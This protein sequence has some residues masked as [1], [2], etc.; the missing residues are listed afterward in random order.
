MTV[1]ANDAP[2]LHP[3]KIGGSN[4]LQ[5]ARAPQE[6]VFPEAWQEELTGS[7]FR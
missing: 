3:P 2:P 7:L 5:D 6:M 4:V 1:T